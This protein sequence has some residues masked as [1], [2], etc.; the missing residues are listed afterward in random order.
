MKIETLAIR[1]T[2]F[3]DE[4]AGAVAAPIYLS[5]TFER[6]ADGTF[7]KN[8]IYSRIDNPNRQ[9]L[10]K[11]IALLENG[12]AGF[13]FASGLAAVA[14]VLQLLNT[15]DHVIAGDDAYYAAMVQMRDIFGHLGISLTQVDMT[16]IQK[17]KQALQPNTRLI[18]VETPSNPLLKITDIQAMA[19]LARENNAL[20]GVDNT[21]ATPI[22]QKPLDLG[23]DL[24]QH[25]TTKYF[26]GHSD[27]L[28]GAL[29]VKN[30]ELAERLRKIQVFGGAVASPFDCWLLTRGIKT[31]PLRVKTQT[32]NARKLA[33]FLATH[34]K[35]E[36]VHYPGL[37]SHP[38]HEI[39]QKQ[40]SGF[41]GMVSFQVRGNQ[42]TAM[43]VAGK[44]ALFT[45][46]TSL[47]GVE[48]LV[49]H[50]RSVEG[51]LSQT[52]EN[53]LRVSVGI[54]DADDLIADLEQALN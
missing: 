51:I 8:F 24:V 54:E 41:G 27:V 19:D 9:L 1:S 28:S 29:V 35:V 36:V 48:S 32:E 30:P 15:G 21:W 45:R 38:G 25:A 50:R 13:A 2:Q 42:E 3:I 34:P 44:L 4:N 40:M 23:A 22:L 20:C 7:A 12:T 14:A 6:E 31:L 37:Q 46:A 17:V 39:A 16:D 5:T 10:E 11:S 47:G 33:D 53:L 26:G 52:P 43:Q 18:W 49:E